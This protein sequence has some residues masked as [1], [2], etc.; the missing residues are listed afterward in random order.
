MP[1]TVTARP[2]FL[3]LMGVRIGV[4]ARPEQNARA[5]SAALT[6]VVVSVAAACSQSA[7][8]FESTDPTSA[9][10]AFVIATGSDAAVL[11][12]WNVVDDNSVL[13]PSRSSS[14]S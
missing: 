6:F 13:G 11:D 2:S 5:R 4:Q 9:G 12:P 1:T 10:R 8:P 14:R 3:S 7:A